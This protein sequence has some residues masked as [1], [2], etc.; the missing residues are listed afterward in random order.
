MTDTEEAQAIA[1]WLIDRQGDCR[2]DDCDDC[3]TAGKAS[4]TIRALLAE[5]DVLRSALVALA[6]RERT[7]EANMA[8]RRK[9]GWYRDFSVENRDLSAAATWN[10]VAK[11][12]RAALTGEAKP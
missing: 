8:F 5:R 3:I 2:C 11:I 10:E 6:D 7:C 9:Q 12:A 4:R 1:Q